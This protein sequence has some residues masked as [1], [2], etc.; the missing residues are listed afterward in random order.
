M[1]YLS[2]VLL[3]F[4]LALQAQV[5]QLWNENFGAGCNSGTLL[6][7]YFSPIGASWTITETG[8]NAS[9]AN[10]WFVSAEE[11]GNSVGQCGSGCGGNPT[12]HVG[13]L[14][15]FLGTDLGAAY[16]EGL[17]GLCDV[18]D[19]GATDKRADS[20]IID[21]S[22]FVG[23]SISFNYIEGGN[24]LDNATLWYFDGTS[25]S[26]LVDLPKTPICANGQGQWTAYTIALPASS[27]NNLNVRI[28][29]RWQ[30]ND[31]GDA[32]DPSFAVD[33]LSA[34]GEFGQDAIP[35][36]IICPSDTTIYTEDYC[37]FMGDFESLTVATDNFDFYPSVVQSPEVETFVSPGTHTITVVAADYS[38]NSNQCSFTL[39]LI[40]DDAPTLT[41]PP[42]IQVQADPGQNS[43]LVSV[44]NPDATDNCAP[45]AVNNDFSATMPVSDLFP[46]GTTTVTYTATD[47]SLNATQCTVDVVVTVSLINCC[48]G[49]LNCDGVINVGDMLILISQFGCIGNSC[50]ADL[51]DDNIVG[52][53][54]LQLFNQLYGTI[55]PQ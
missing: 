30:N 27:N 53:S 21:C 41:C 42:T 3:L 45:P 55:C 36:T 34:S 9:V 11:N 31:D 10:T 12:L 33:N 25:W 24:A 1:R 14:N 6:T 47:A 50:Y 52:V 32:T 7:D 16:Y 37:Y 19:C 39:T 17:E 48:L 28:G 23:V 40:D 5:V 2:L 13:A 8:Y 43:A 29:F 44:P 49:D 18:V 20:P 35:P 26:L 15:S 54:D 22:A 46:I 4:P 51:D 38:G